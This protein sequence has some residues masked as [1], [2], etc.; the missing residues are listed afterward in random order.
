MKLLPEHRAVLKKRL[1]DG[2]ISIVPSRIIC[3]DGDVILEGGKLPLIYDPKMK[4]VYVWNRCSRNSTGVV[5]V[6]TLIKAREI[7]RV[8]YTEVEEAATY[9]TA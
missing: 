8:W 9:E 4:E 7:I 3:R 5:A 6:D 1:R 2:D